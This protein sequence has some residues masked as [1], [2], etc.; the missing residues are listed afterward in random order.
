[1]DFWVIPE[2]KLKWTPNVQTA[3]QKEGRKKYNMFKATGTSS[4]EGVTRTNQPG[5]VCLLA[6]GNA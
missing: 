5:G 1:M 6:S 2:T 4:M 3:F